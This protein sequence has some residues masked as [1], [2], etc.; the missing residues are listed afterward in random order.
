MVKSTRRVVI[1]DSISGTLTSFKIFYGDNK[2][3][4]AEGTSFVDAQLAGLMGPDY[5]RTEAERA[6]ERFK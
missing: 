4:S 5:I 2:Q 6:A 3:P 1:G